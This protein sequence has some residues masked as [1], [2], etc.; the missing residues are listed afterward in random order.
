MIDYNKPKQKMAYV[1]G[2]DNKD[3]LAKR[4]YFDTH[5]FVTLILGTIL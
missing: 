3:H 4:F 5:I 2:V 1:I